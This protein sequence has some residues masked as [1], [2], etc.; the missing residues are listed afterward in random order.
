MLQGCGHRHGSGEFI[1]QL[2]RQGGVIALLEQDLDFDDRSKFMSQLAN[3]TLNK[4]SVLNGVKFEYS[5]RN[6]RTHGFAGQKNIMVVT[7]ATDILVRSYPKDDQD[8][9]FEE[10]MGMKH[11]DVTEMCR[12]FLTDND[13]LLFIDE[14]ESHEEWDLIKRQLLCESTRACIVVLTKDN[15]VATYCVDHKEYRLLNLRDL[16]IKV[17]THVYYV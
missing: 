6:I 9:V 12:K 14:M 3:D 11:E 17:C 16:M 8:D 10:L 5:Y 4:L 1:W 2:R 13:Y 15:N 7:M